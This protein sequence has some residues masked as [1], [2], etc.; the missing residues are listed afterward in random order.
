MLSVMAF[1]LTQALIMG[2]HAKQARRQHHTQD[3]LPVREPTGGEGDWPMLVAG[4]QEW[5]GFQLDWGA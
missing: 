1:L 5:V 3:R 4:I 2:A